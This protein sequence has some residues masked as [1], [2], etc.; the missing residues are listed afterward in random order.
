MTVT[1][2]VEWL[3]TQDQGAT[4][5]VVTIGDAPTWEAYGPAALVELDV[6]NAG[7]VEYTDF[8]GNQFTKE[9]AP[10]FN[11]RYLTFGSTD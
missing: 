5:Q 10:H 2:L 6:T 9:D 4:V 7:H 3:K 1:Q 11:Q 8:R